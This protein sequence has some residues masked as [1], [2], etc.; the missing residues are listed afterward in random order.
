MLKHLV[1][2]ILGEQDA[3]DRV[4]FKHLMSVIFEL[5]L[6]ACFLVIGVILLMNMVIVLLNNTYD[7]TQVRPDHI[8]HFVV[9]VMG[10][11]PGSLG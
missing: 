11:R 7:R 4:E 10:F 6:I 8:L 5:L 9:V 2:S 3:F 1:W